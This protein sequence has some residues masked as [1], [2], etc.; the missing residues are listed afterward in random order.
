MNPAEGAPIEVEPAHMW[1]VLADDGIAKRMLEEALAS[2]D[3]EGVSYADARLIEAEELR[4]YKTLESSLD[5]RVENNLG[6]GIRVLYRGS[7]GFASVP[8]EDPRDVV[9]A[10]HRALS[11]ARNASKVTN[12]YRTE[13]APLAATRGRYETQVI[14]DP[15]AVSS[16]V[17]QELLAEILDSAS[18]PKAVV[19]AQAGLNAKR[20][21]RHF[22]NTEGSMQHQHLME[23]GA[24]ALVS[25][26]G[27]GTVQRRS[28][29]NSFHG[30]TA[31]AGWEYVAGLSMVEEADR[32]GREAVELLTAPQAPSGFADI[33][34]GPAQ[35]ALQIH[36]S[37]GHALELD[38]ILGDEANYAGTSFI[39]ADAIGRLRYGSPAV[40]ITSDPTVEGTRGSFAFDDE[41]VPA[42]RQVLIEKGIVRNFLS[43]RDSAARIGMPSIGA[44]RSDGWG[45]TP[46]CF[47][48]NV[49]LEPGTGSTTE[50]EERLGDGYYIDDNRSWSI[51]ERRSNFQFGTEVAYEVKNGKRG[52]LLRG[53]SYGGTTPEFWQSVEAI[54][55]PEEFKAFGMPCGKGEPKQW[56]FLGHGASPTLVRNVRIGVD[57]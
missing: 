46:V 29:P 28:F 17:R 23:T 42:T 25:A 21:H 56:G 6:I 48:T 18:A 36:E 37:T 50:L 45:Y 38:R 33:I 55:G 39:G 11:N 15:F 14:C 12:A 43:T 44:A 9:V 19:M 8:I 22:A 20:Q 26:A 30:N 54:A 2:V 27:N 7:W 1:G 32:I 35:M 49:F 57:R 5:E 41:G 13:L 51:D 34:I 40:N 53:F 52:R 16:S 3:V 31:Q 24:M 4:L 47:A 10:G